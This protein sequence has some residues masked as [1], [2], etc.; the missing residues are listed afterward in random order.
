MRT[1]RS[2][3]WRR[4]K[5]KFHTMLNVALNCTAILAFRQVR[6]RCSDAAELL[7]QLCKLQTHMLLIKS[8][9]ERRTRSNLSF[10]MHDQTVR[11]VEHSRVLHREQESGFRFLVASRHWHLER[12]G[13][14]IENGWNVATCMSSENLVANLIRVNER[15]ANSFDAR[16]RNW[17]SRWNVQ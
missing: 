17:R 12:F 1:K 5:A 15:V 3:D 10:R 6:Q 4:V 8:H 11:V 13:A 14:R 7:V 16:R 2:V 9:N